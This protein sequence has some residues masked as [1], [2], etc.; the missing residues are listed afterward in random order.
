MDIVSY[1]WQ[2]AAASSTLL[3]FHACRLGSSKRSQAAVLGEGVGVPALG[4]AHVVA[5]AAGVHCLVQALVVARLVVSSLMVV[6]R[7]HV[8]G[9]WHLAVGVEL[10]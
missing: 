3:R 2:C 8:V 9:L 10:A 1:R 6:L 7:V 4:C 5:I